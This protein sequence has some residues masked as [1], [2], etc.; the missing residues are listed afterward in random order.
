MPGTSSI[1][2]WHME[3]PRLSKTIRRVTVVERDASGAMQAV[4]VYVRRRRRK[5]QTRGLKPVE[6]AV[7]A[8]SRAGDAFTTTYRSR[9]GRSNRK[10]RDGWLRD[11]LLNL[12]NAGDK[13]RRKLDLT[14]VLG[15]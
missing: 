5:R 7:R 15:W 11:S 12:A 9:H 2:G 8:I 14:K 6:R 4:A 13:A 3:L 10:R 1:A